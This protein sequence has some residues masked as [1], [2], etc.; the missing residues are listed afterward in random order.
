MDDQILFAD[1]GE[2]VAT[3]VADAVWEAGDIG[4]E[5]QL[6]PFGQDQLGQI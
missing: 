2:T 4:L 5:Q 1:G 3:M 6:G